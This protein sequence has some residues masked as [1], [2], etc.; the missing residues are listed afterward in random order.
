M[1]DVASLNRVQKAQE[2]FIN[3]SH[4][5]DNNPAAIYCPLPLR[6][7][8]RSTRNRTSHGIQR[9]SVVQVPTIVCRSGFPLQ[10]MGFSQDNPEQ[11]LAE[12]SFRCIAASLG[13]YTAFPTL[14]FGTGRETHCFPAA[15]GLPN[16]VFFHLLASVSNL[17][18]YFR[19]QPPIH[20][21][22]AA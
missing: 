10:F 5:L 19:P 3:S 1:K 2:F 20:S 9:N 12:G 7:T 13:S 22:C 16:S 8:G 11:G 4:P 17:W 21:N 14:S 6:Q 18:P 15:Q